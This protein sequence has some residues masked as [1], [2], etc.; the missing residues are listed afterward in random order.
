MKLRAII[1]WPSV[2]GALVKAVRE[3]DFVDLKVWSMKDLEEREEECLKGL[4]DADVLL[5]NVNADNEAWRKVEPTVAEMCR[6]L[7]T[8]FIPTGL[9]M[10]SLNN[11]DRKV[12]ETC[13]RYFSNSGV[14]NLRNMVA[15][16]AAELMGLPVEVPPPRELPR[17]GIYH[18]DAPDC[19]A[20]L[21]VYLEWYKPPG[22]MTAGLI[23]YRS[24]W[25][26][27]NCD[28]EIAL[29]REL[30]NQGVGVVPV[31]TESVGRSDSG[32]PPTSEVISRLFMTEDGTG[33][34]DAL[35]NLQFALLSGGG[36]G[37]EKLSVEEGVKLLEKLDVPVFHPIVL[38]SRT[39][40][41]WRSELDSVN[42]RSIGW[43]VAM[44]EFE[45]M[46]EPLVG[47]ALR[48]EQDPGAGA[49][50]DRYSPIDERMKKIAARIK[51]WINLRKKP[52][53][54]RRAAFILH[55]N[56]C[57][58]VEASVGGGAHLDT[59]ESVAIILERMEA[60]GYAVADFPK[61]GKE[62]ITT[63]MDRKAIS[64]FRWTTVDEIVNKGGALAQLS[65]DE[66]R[67]WFDT[68]PERIRERMIETWGNPPGEELNG[69][70][71]AMVHDGKILVTGVQ[72]GNAV[73]CV[74]PKRG[75]AGPRCDGKVCKILHDPEIP[76]PHQYLA[77][78]RYLE[79][80]FG[81]DVI[82]HVGTHGNLE[83]LP[84][85]PVGLSE[86]CL[87]DMA[88]GNMPHLYIYNADNPP[89]GP[90]PSAEAT[91]AWWT[92]CRP[93]SPEANS[94]THW[95]ISRST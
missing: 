62:L 79:D 3:L 71:A 40:E 7:P 59:L 87:P 45:G 19:F 83:F 17:E 13:F 48:R 51:G 88:I 30:E 22:T 46:I 49:V 93:F 44:P 64:E 54:R 26:N 9:A 2:L 74:Q 23:F 18:P 95:R 1:A 16:L 86:S 53:D 5:L 15:F 65:V 61:N 70:P 39:E 52:V 20:N 75:C 47:G 33:R 6:T 11:V 28:V 43:A 50:M 80:H 92:T 85:K 32:A 31:F 35:V 89:K 82:V 72:Y 25:V 21:A 94:T 56:P 90:L 68:F 77:T 24:Y 57:A 8:V 81:A 4:S 37:D 41:E 84:G 14:E 58:S 60:E 66:Y 73:V 55:N 10:V 91:P 34:V 12:A 63:I 69:V 27:G 36:D 38:Y 29:I 76:P 42:G 78:Y 67:R